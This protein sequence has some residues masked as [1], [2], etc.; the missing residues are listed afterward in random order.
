MDKESN[1]RN[2]SSSD[3][4]GVIGVCGVV[5]NLVI[6]VLSDNGFKVA[7]TDSKAEENVILNIP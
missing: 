4:F 7:G 3:V 6:R 1:N 5:G 2:Y